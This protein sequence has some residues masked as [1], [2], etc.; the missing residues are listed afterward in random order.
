MN[1]LHITARG[2]DSRNHPRVLSLMCEQCRVYIFTITN[3]C[4]ETPHQFL[5]QRGVPQVGVR[6]VSVNNDHQSAIILHVSSIAANHHKCFE[7]LVRETIS[8][9]MEDLSSH[10]SFYRRRCM[11]RPEHSNVGETGASWCEG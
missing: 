6:C 5:M 9:W 11:I 7:K 4:S 1:L 2:R 10:M 8:L 3:G